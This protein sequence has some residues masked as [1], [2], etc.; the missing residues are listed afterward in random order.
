[1]TRTARP[2]RSRRIRGGLAGNAATV[3]PGYEYA[4]RGA[5]FDVTVGSNSGFVTARQA[6]SRD[7]LCVAKRGYDAPTC[8]GTPDGAGAF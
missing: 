5:L 3:A 1:M 8:L 2:D 6:C 7:Y 4:H